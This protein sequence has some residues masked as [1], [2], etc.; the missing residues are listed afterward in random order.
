MSERFDDVLIL[1]YGNPGRLDDGLGPAFGEAMAQ[2]SLAG[3]TVDIDYQL[4]VEEAERMA[5]F[6]TVI[7][8]DASVN[9]REPFFFRRIEAKPA[10]GF[11]SHHLDPEN[12]LALT[13]ELFHREPEGFALGIRG[14]DFNEFGETLSASAQK[15]LA[16]ALQFILPVIRARNFNNAAAALNPTHYDNP[17]ACQGGLQCKTE[18][19]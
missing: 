5:Q 17:T 7:F 2:L 19:M 15:N 8:A 14:Y 6:K 1:C 16:A 4:T 11:T 13:Q 12:L 9:S 10:L 18:N 3:V